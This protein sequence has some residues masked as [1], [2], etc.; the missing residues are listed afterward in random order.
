MKRILAG[1]VVAAVM[2]S[3]LVVVSEFWPSHGNITYGDGAHYEGDLLGGD[4]H[5][6][7]VAMLPS[8]HRHEGEFRTFVKDG[9]NVTMPHGQGVSTG[10]DGSRYEGEW[11]EGSFHGQGVYTW[12]DGARHE[13]EFREGS[14]HGQGVET[15]PDGTRFEG[16]WR[17]D[18]FVV[19]VK[20]WPDGERRSFP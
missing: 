16:E 19:G 12:P 18:V 1:L 20:T 3:G 6:Q 4:P 17:E 7:G 14:F 13:G 2:V 5:G 11:R 10:P 9:V 8:G 15:Y